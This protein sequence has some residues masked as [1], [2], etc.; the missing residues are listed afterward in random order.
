M[1]KL[2]AVQIRGIRRLEIGQ[3]VPLETFRIR[4]GEGFDGGRG[5]ARSAVGGNG[6]EDVSVGGEG[7]GAA[8]PELYV[9]SVS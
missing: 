3:R 4:R 9:L 5:W 8:F 7:E 1:R 6:E 2:L